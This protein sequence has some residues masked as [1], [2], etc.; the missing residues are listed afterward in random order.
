MGDELRRRAVLGSLAAGAAGAAG[1]TRLGLGDDTDRGQETSTGGTEQTGTPRPTETPERSPT[2]EGQS[3]PTYPY[4][5]AGVPPLDAKPDPETL[6]PVLTASHVTDVEAEF[7]ADPFLFVEDGEWHMFFEV[8]ADRGVIAHA[9]SDDRGKTWNYDRIVLRR[10]YHVSFPLVFKWRGEYYMTT[11]EGRSSPKARLYRATSFPTEWEHA[12][13]LYDPAQWGHTITDHALFRWGDRW[14][15]LAG[16]DNEHTYAYYSDELTAGSWTPH[17]NNPVVESRPEASRPGGRPLVDNDR[18]LV[19]YQD[20]TEYYGKNV[21]AFEVTTLSPSSYDDSELPSS[22]VIESAEESGQWN[23]HRMHHYDPWYL[24]DGEGW[25]V[26]VDG[27][28]YGNHGWAIG[29][30]RVPEQA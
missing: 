6:N 9:T 8:L 25:R 5:E 17:E 1:C 3:I 30:Y 22:P 28:G 2:P 14:W 12:V 24:G 16:V 15:S 4:Q 27:D 7:V 13:D 21:R 26:V 10:P 18:V 11:E 29:I 23:A 20:S 19:F